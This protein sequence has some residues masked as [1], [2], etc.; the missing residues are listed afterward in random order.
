MVFIPYIIVFLFT[1]LCRIYKLFYIPFER[2]ID[3]Q[4]NRHFQ[5]T[6]VTKKGDARIKLGLAIRGVPPF[7]IRR[8]NF[9][10]HL[11]KKTKCT[12][13]LTTGDNWVDNHLFFSTQTP[14]ILHAAL[15]FN[16]GLKALKI[17]FHDYDIKSLECINNVI[18]ISSKKFDHSDLTNGFIQDRLDQLR[19]LAR[20]MEASAQSRA[21]AKSWI[22]QQ[23]LFFF[24]M[25]VHSAL[26]ALGIYAAFAA[27][28]EYQQLI[29][30]SAFMFASSRVAL[31]ICISWLLIILNSLWSSSWLPMALLDFLAVGILGIFL[32]VLFLMREINIV[33][34]HS[35]PMVLK[36]TVLNKN[37][38]LMCQA[39]GK[40]GAFPKYHSL[41][42]TECRGSEARN[43]SL[44]WYKNMYPAC[45]N[46]SGFIFSIKVNPLLKNQDESSF[47]VS[48]KLYDNTQYGDFIVIPS[49]SGFLGYPWI[50]PM[51]LSVEGNQ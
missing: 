49:K 47:N 44:K 12:K 29:S 13:E 27:Y 30:P 16:D 31:I 34:D 3:K 6:L 37:C 17:L 45:A 20:A 51:T 1:C 41:T 32:S 7:S 48:S 35:S 14:E 42:E 40:R 11:L 43:S 4:G 8:E 22:S 19:L 38:Y 26:L 50:N 36:R 21:F 15:V 24:F 2:I 10:Y 9:Y 23:N 33:F 18:W 25:V 46:S 5:H 39:R 28:Y